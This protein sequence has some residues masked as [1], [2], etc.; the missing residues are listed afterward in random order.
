MPKIRYPKS[1]F[2]RIMLIEIYLQTYRFRWVYFNS[3]MEHIPVPTTFKEIWMQIW[4]P[5][6]NLYNSWCAKTSFKSL[7]INILYPQY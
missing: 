6:N 4:Y 2:L 7:Q 1:T 3:Q 5:K